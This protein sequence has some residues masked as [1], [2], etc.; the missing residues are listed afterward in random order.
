[1]KVSVIHYSNAL[2]L[3]GSSFLV[4]AATHKG[5]SQYSHFTDKDKT[6][7]NTSHTKEEYSLWLPS[8]PLF[9]CLVSG[10]RYN[11]KISFSESLLKTC[12]N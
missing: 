3:R 5:C 8:V 2:I 10:I 1:M 12:L 11:V 9:V 6:P 7:F 4:D